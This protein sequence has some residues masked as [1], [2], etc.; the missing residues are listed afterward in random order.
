MYRP[1]DQPRNYNNNDG[2]RQ[3]ILPDA[4]NVGTII[5]TSATSFA[6]RHK[7]ITG[8]YIFGLLI[9]L[10]AGSGLKL[11]VD[12]ARTYNSIMS[13]IN[14]EA[15]YDASHD[16]WQAQQAYRAS[17]GWFTCDSLC[18]RN[19]Q[20]MNQAKYVLDEIRQEGNARMSDAK[21]SVGLF[22]E[23][24]V[25]EVKDSFWGHFYGGKQFAKRQSM[26]DAMF[27]GIRHMGRDESFVEYALRVLMQILVNFSMGLLMALVIFIFGLWSI[28]RSYQPN[29]LVAV[30]FFISAVCAAFA[31][32]TSYL[33][34]I[35]GATAGGLYGMAKLAE[36]N[37]RAARLENNRRQ[38]IE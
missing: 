36:T 28:V 24:G 15:E 20:R 21:A 19:K 32:V 22:S 6:R 8:G 37:A 16:Y 23:V 1:Q 9:I 7:I 38:H 12:Q 5:V 35:Y 13:T 11:T 29:P 17:K 18:E 4:A 14:L 2:G 10:F 34:A 3:V 26:W 30:L 31:F 27:M 33:L 25:G